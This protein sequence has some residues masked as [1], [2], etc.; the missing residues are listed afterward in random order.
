MKKILFVIFVAILANAC[1][2]DY[3]QEDRIVKSE[4]G[5]LI[6]WDCQALPVPVVIGYDVENKKFKQAVF[7]VVE[8]INETFKRQMVLQPHQGFASRYQNYISIGNMEYE[9]GK[10]G[11]ASIYLDDDK[12]FIN[13]VDIIVKDFNDYQS[14]YNV[15]VHEFGH[16]FGLKHDEN[17]CSTMYYQIKSSCTFKT[18]KYSK[19]DVKILDG[20]YDG[21]SK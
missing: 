20:F 5:F 1:T 15:L 10:G 18:D 6:G 8:Y 4:T 3:K 14:Y 11:R 19:Y 16:A 17:T 7:D 21:C 9:E 13:H 12:R 2:K